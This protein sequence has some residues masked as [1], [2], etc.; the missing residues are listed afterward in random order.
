MFFKPL[1][2]A[3]VL[4]SSGV[5]ISA[6]TFLYAEGASYLSDDP[7]ACANCHVMGDHYSAWLKSS[8]HQVAGCNDCHTSHANV[9]A[10]YGTKAVNGFL[11]SYAFTTDTFPDA[12]RIREFNAG[13]TDAACRHC[14]AIA[15]S[16]ATSAHSEIE[17]AGG[18]RQLSCLHCHRT[19]G[20]WVR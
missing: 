12:I 4:V 8:H 1:L 13:V 3:T 20:H 16:I 15:E 14:H 5:G 6:Y 17:G 11:H 2:A 18:G 7:A 10:K 9:A 19:V